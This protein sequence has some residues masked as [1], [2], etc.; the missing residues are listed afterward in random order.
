M[1]QNK[2]AGFSLGFTSSEGASIELVLRSLR[3]LF[4]PELCLESWKIKV[5]SQY[6][7]ELVVT[8]LKHGVPMLRGGRSGD[9]KLRT[10]EISLAHRS[11]ALA[12][13]DLAVEAPNQSLLHEFYADRFTHVEPTGAGVAR[14][15]FSASSA[16]CRWY[17]PLL[18][19][20]VFGSFIETPAGG[21]Y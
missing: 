9:G 19:F 16:L 5:G 20:S 11:W 15:D 17:F 10:M 21:F 18:M 14:I 6:F 7:P 1:Y 8:G 12:I 2:P 13:A 4:A 3:A